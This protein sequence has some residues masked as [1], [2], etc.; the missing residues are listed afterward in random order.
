M[1]DE[2]LKKN[3]TSPPKPL[4]LKAGSAWIRGSISTAFYH[5]QC[6]KHNYDR[7]DDSLPMAH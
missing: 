3:G 4:D 5:Q 1:Q 2:E 6:F 7:S